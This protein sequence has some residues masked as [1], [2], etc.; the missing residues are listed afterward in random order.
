M[1][2]TITSNFEIWTSALLNK[3]SAGRD[4]NG[5]QETYGIKKLREL[6]LELA[7]RGKMV[8]QDSNDEP[9]SALLEH[10]AREKV[11]LRK[12]GNLKEEKP[13]PGI[14][15]TEKPFGLPHGW[16]WVRFGSIAQHNSGKTLDQGRNTGQLQDYITTSNLY[17]G[18]FDL[19]NIR[20]MPIGD[21][22][23]ERCTA[24]KGDLLI[25]EG[26]EAGRAA[27][28]PYDKGICFQNHVHR[29]RFYGEIDPYFAYRFLEKL[30]ATGEIDQHR[31]GVGISNMSSKALA[32][33]VLPLPPLAE[34][35]RIVAKLDEL[36]ALCDRLEQQQTQSVDA[37]QTL[38]ETVL[39]TLTRAASR[40]ELTGAWTRIANNVGTLFT[41]EHSIDLLRQTIRQLAIMGKIVP[42]DPNDEPA[43][44]LL[45]GIA[46]EK[47]KHIADGGIGKQKHYPEIAAQEQLFAAPAGWQWVRLDT[48]FNVIVDCPHSTPKFTDSGFLCLDTNS[49]KQGALIEAKFRYVD[50]ETYLERIA[51]LTPDEGDIV[52]ARE[53]SVGES[54]VLPA[55][56]TCCL[57]Q[58][59]MLFR[60]S[61]R[62]HSEFLRMAMSSPFS[63]KALLE[64]H[65]GIGAKHVN[66]GDMRKFAIALPPAAEQRRIVAKV[67][68]LMALCA[69]LEARIADAQITQIHLADA[70]V[71]QAVV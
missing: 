69:S 21:D 52:F 19:D 57:G 66:V 6:I 71:E 42:Q 17:W 8:P 39:D 4:G 33:L 3:W 30:N 9:A 63:L 22:E 49:F 18:R 65:K 1:S 28:W 25:C 47:Q 12:A 43:G 29:A 14:G 67:D 60:P 37:H 23:L 31:K 38:V 54:V 15:E 55:G 27:V 11:R 13:L 61:K 56:L 58:R 36:M 59:V 53:G 51:R 68:E 48:L 41:T 35:R 50:A 26:G 16:E 62:L 40:Q 7:M 34:Q 5:K 45:E 32:S 20:Q 2:G 70:V 44:V 10:I 64:L 24:R 46:E